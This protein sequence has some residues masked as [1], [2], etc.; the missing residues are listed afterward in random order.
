M[1][2]L[3]GAVEEQTPASRELRRR[4]Q[5]RK[6]QSDGEVPLRFQDIQMYLHGAREKQIT[7][8]M[9]GFQFV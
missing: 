1:L 2:V 4:L 7:G 9:E 5:R 6:E 3:G 8:Y